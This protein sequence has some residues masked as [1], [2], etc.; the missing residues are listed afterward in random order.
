M[1]LNHSFG[2]LGPEKFVIHSLVNPKVTAVCYAGKKL[3]DSIKK[4][5]CGSQVEMYGKTA[6][7][8]VRKPE[9]KNT[10]PWTLGHRA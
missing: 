3:L 8:C 10:H 1:D 7:T 6:I 2:I 4:R 9:G 5:L